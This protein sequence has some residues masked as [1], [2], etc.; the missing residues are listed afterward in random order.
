MK[1]LE[2]NNVNLFGQCGKSWIADLPQIIEA[3]AIKWG[4][5]KIE[6]VSN[7]SWNYVARAESR[8][9]GAV[10]IKASI[11]KKLIADEIKALE[12]FSG[13]GMIKRLDYN[14]ENNAILLQQ[15]IPGKSL[16]DFYPRNSVQV[17]EN[18]ADVVLK[19]NLAKNY[20][21]SNFKHVRDWLRVFDRIDKNQL[22]KGVVDEAQN[23]S[24]NLLSQGAKEFV[25]HGDLHLDNIISDR[26]VYVAIDPKGIVGP[27]EFEVA[28]FDFID[29]DEIA[30]GLDIPQMFEE[31]SKLL[32]D[33][34][35]LD[36]KN[37]TDWVFVRLVLGACWMIEDNSKDD[38]FLNRLKAIFSV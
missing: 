16:K 31:R 2:Q 33:F 29:L 17:T 20:N 7:M 19:L 21:H 13:Q 5:S 25:L 28:C 10:C 12:H 4:L 3:I 27:I 11:D 38:M 1:T 18:Y 6:P 32:S 14:E 24:N 37:L 30:Q 35:N 23:I 34:L 8:K 26:D 22:P 36:Q 9:Y 15:A